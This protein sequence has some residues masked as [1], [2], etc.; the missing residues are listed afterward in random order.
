MLYQYHGNDMETLRQAAC[1]LLGAAPPPPLVP[2]RLVV[3]NVGMAKWLRAGVAMHSG[4]AANL[5]MESPAVFLDGLARS[6]LGEAPQRCGSP[7][8][9]KEQ[10]ALRIMRELPLLQG[11]P[12]FETVAGYLDGSDPQRRLHALGLR[13]AELYD[14]YLLY[15][16]EWMLAWEAD[17]A[18]HEPALAGNAWQA[19]LWRALV[20]RLQVERPDDAHGARRL[21]QLI[22]HLGDARPLAV[23]LPER[24]I[25]FGL[26]AL[27]PLFIEALGAL[28]NRTDVHLFQFNPCRAYWYDTES[29]RTLARWRVQEP[30]RAALS[31]GGNPLLDAWGGIGRSGLERLLARDAARVFDLFCEAPARGVLGAVQHDVLCHELP[32]QPRTLEQ[33]DG[34]LVFA[35]AHSRLREIEALQ[36]Q[37]LHLLASIEGLRPRDITVMA[38]DIGAYAGAIEAVFRLPRNDPRQLPFTIADRDGSTMN[39]LLQGF[40][41]LLRLPESRFERSAVLA[42]LGTPAIG[43]RFGIGAEALGLLRERIDTAA[44]RWGFDA[45][46]LPDGTPGPERNSWHF[47]LERLL[48]GIAFEEGTLYDGVAALDPGGH[49]GMEYLGRLADFLER[50]GYYALELVAARPMDAWLELLHALLTDFFHD[51]PENQEDLAALHHA[52]AETAT[53][54]EDAGHDGPLTRSVLHELLAARFAAQDSTHHFLRGGVNFCQLT[55]LRSIPFRVVC[56]LGMDAEDFPRGAPPPAFDLIARAP[57]AGDPSRREDDRYLFLEALLSARDCLY[58][59]RV[60]R[61]ERGNAEREP[62]LPLSELRNYLDAWW[63]AAEDG[64]AASTVLTREHRLKPFDRAYFEKDGTLWSFRSEWL[65]A[66]GEPAAP[67]DFCTQPLPA[68]ALT[69]LALDALLAFMRSPCRGFLEQRLGVRFAHSDE[70]DADEEPLALDTLERWQ[71]REALIGTKLAGS[72]AEAGAARFTATGQLPHGYAGRRALEETLDDCEPL[73]ETASTWAVL[74]ARSEDFALEFDGLRLHGTLGGLRG[75]RLLRISVSK[76]HGGSLLPFW[77][78]HLCCCAG[79]LASGSAE[80]HCLDARHTLPVLDSAQALEHLADLLQ[81][82]REGMRRPLPLFPKTSFA[83]AKALREHG[84]PARALKTARSRFDDNHNQRGE[85]SER[86]VLR[87]FAEPGEVLGEEFARLAA[88]VFTPLLE[89]LDGGA[90]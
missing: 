5:R 21:Q 62:A 54:L 67:E 14:R 76:A 64:R 20:G 49:D 38:P 51:S 37:L 60:A 43:A 63:L 13:L 75:G 66:A 2:E 6:L 17:T 30:E 27:A 32:A 53:A 22:E 34:S 11:Q 88:R 85:G 68:P 74:D 84:E 40:L 42:L 81:I 18:V 15:R 61:D 23:E 87:V 35:E 19:T 45:G 26:G 3:P 69:E 12:G 4:I 57:R 77:I 71:L 73:L 36:D 46:P 7:A 47:G 56:L 24:V 29:E 25:G 79:N 55:P 16:P 86:S 39:P 80:L 83:Y 58:I 59:S 82:Y 10:L 70:A 72:S 52:I 41:H 31:R 65:P 9:S 28:A 44:I 90:E 78:S 8:W 50:L 33:D 1:T 48:L 89:A